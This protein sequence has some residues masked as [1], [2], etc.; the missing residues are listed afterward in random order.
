MCGFAFIGGHKDSYSSNIKEILTAIHHRGPDNSDFISQKGFSLGSCRL[1]IFD[2]SERGK[3]P[4]K[5]KTGKYYIV[6]N[7]EI[8]NFQELKKQFDIST[9]SGTDTE[10]LLELF[11]KLGRKSLDYLNGIFSFIIYDQKNNS[12]FGARDRLGVKPFFYYQNLREFI[13]SSEIKGI[14][15]QKQHSNISD[16]NITQISTYLKTTFYDYSTST[17]YK[18]IKQLPQAHYFEYDICKNKLKIARYW[19][20]NF[21]KEASSKNIFEQFEYDL[22]NSFQLQLGSDTDIA[23]NISS[24]IDSK[25]M[26]KVLKKLNLRNV[27]YNSYYFASKEFSEKENLKEFARNED[28]QVNFFKITPEDIIKNFDEVFLSQDEP[29]PG[30]PTIAKH[31]LIKRSS[32]KKTKVILEAQG[33][34]DFAGGYKYIFPFYLLS[35]SREKKYIKYVKEFLNFMFKEKISPLNMLKFLNNSQKSFFNGGISADGSTAV[36]NIFKKKLEV[37]SNF[38]DNLNKID[39]KNFSHLKKIIYRDLFFCKLPRILRSCDRASMYSSKELRVPLLDHNIV[40]FFF[41]LEDDNIIRNGNLRYFYREFCKKKFNIKDS[42]V[43]KMYVSDPQTI[44]M[45]NEL[46]DWAYDNLSCKSFKLGEFI[47]QKKLLIS[48][49]KFKN[50]RFIQNSNIYWQVINLQ[51]LFSMQN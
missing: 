40:E 41:N 11:I 42:F 21:N 14:L 22:L 31:L 50:N 8:Y 37:D 16:L 36:E 39:K 32:E 33:G 9:V 2:H 45:K 7:G 26:V 51:K 46:Y 25:L 18:N 15:T 43:K 4:M 38:L 44:W 49:E 23:V 34:D 29:F 24:G 20:L 10:V 1:S 13:I 6:Y 28:I 47:D 30:V 3:M 12:L 27:T 5:D 17:F 19:D 48:F 35:L